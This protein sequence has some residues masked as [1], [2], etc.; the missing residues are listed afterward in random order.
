MQFFEP[1]QYCSSSEF[2]G[3]TTRVER[4]VRQERFKFSAQLSTCSYPLL[5]LPAEGACEQAFQAPATLCGSHLICVYPFSRLS[6]PGVFDWWPES[7]IGV[8][9]NLFFYR[10]SE[11]NKK[12]IDDSS[13]SHD[14]HGCWQ[15]AQHLHYHALTEPVLLKMKR[16]FKAPRADQQDAATN[17]PD[18]VPSTPVG[19]V[20]TR[21]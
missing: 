17:D 12:L 16:L 15:Q 14:W 19:S 11:E 2:A 1:A 5:A 10:T 9:H 4:P 18:I 6:Q 3:W 8:S 13:V 21:W 7:K 20:E